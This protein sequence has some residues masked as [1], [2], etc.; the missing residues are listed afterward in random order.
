MVRKREHT[1]AARDRQINRQLNK[2][3]AAAE[4]IRTLETML[5]K[6]VSW[7]RRD[8]LWDEETIR[9]QLGEKDGN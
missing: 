4:E 2:L 9:K 5:D 8:N 1:I 7:I 6:A 3:A